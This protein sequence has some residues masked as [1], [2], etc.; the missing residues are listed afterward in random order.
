MASINHATL[1]GY[2]NDDLYA[3]TVHEASN[4]YNDF[5]LLRFGDVVEAA[6][7]KTAAFVVPPRKTVSRITDQHIRY[8]SYD[9][10]TNGNMILQVDVVQDITGTQPEET[11]TSN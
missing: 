10:T 11:Q 3:V 6:S 2:M 4:S 5:F 8:N 7:L 9:A 1:T